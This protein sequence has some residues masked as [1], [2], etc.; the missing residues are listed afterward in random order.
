MTLSYQDGGLLAS[1]VKNALIVERDIVLEETLTMCWLVDN[2]ILNLFLDDKR[3]S[4]LENIVALHLYRK[5]KES[6][7]YLKGNKV[8]IDLY[9]SDSNTA[10]EVAYS[11][12]DGDAYNREVFNLVEFNKTSKEVARLIIVTYEE[13][14]TIKVDDKI[15][16]AVPLKKFLLN[17]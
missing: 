17:Y 16:E 5:H 15:I 1:C 8:D 4:L 3:S 12:G 7:Y 6:L 2:G 14:R 9:L 13:E 10:I 11:I